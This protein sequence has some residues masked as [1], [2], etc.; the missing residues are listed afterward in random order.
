[1]AQELYQ[2]EHAFG[3][4]DT[5]QSYLKEVKRLLV[6]IR[7]IFN[8]QEILSV[9]RSSISNFSQNAQRS[10]PSSI[11]DRN[12]SGAP[13]FQPAAGD[14]R[15]L[16]EAHDE[17]PSNEDALY[18][19][20]SNMID[21]GQQAG[22]ARNVATDLNMDSPSH[23]NVASELVIQQNVERVGQIVQMNEKLQLLDLQGNQTTLKV[24]PVILQKLQMVAERKIKALILD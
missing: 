1:M 21:A 18:A 4:P 19:Y 13:V 17:L 2:M 9:S 22:Y 14:C 7:Y 3:Q 10:T 23:A 5:L 12:K 24:V 6:K 11:K 16:V 15:T 20:D 8:P